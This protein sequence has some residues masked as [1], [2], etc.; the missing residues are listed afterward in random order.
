M[1]R[2]AATVAASP[3]DDPGWVPPVVLPG[4][5][6]DHGNCPSTVQVSITLPDG[7]VLGFCG[8]HGREH[9]RQLASRGIQPERVGDLMA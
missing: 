8:H 1:G 5:E 7:K 3:A 6:C 2:L 9:S 4:E